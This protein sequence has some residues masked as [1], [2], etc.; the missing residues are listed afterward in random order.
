M[1]KKLPVL[2]L[3]SVF[4]IATCGLIYELIA[5][6]LASYLLGDSVTQFSTIIGVYLFSMGLGSWI[7]KYF[8][9]N[10]LGWFI[11]I[12][13]LVGLVGGT[14][15]S[16]L[17]LVF[18]SVSSFRIILYGLI[19]ITGILVGL[20]IPLLMRIL[21]DRFEFKDLV[22][23][24][25]TFDYI[26]ALIASLVFPLLLIPYLGIVRTA[27]LFGMLN[28]LVALITCINFK[29]E[30][31]GA[32]YLQS[33]SMISLVALLTGFIYANTI[34]NFS[35]SLTYSDTIIFSKSTPYQRIIITKKGRD[36][37]LFLNGNLQFSSVDEYRYHEALIHPVLQALP[38]AKNVLVMGG[39]DGLAVREILKY[40]QIQT[41]TLVDLDKEM[42]KLFR[43]NEMLLKLNNR[44]FLSPKVTVINAD[45]FSWAR[46]QRKVYDAIIIDFPD[47]SNYSVGKL[48]TNAFYAIV[49]H[50]LKPDGIMVVQST[51]PYVA[52]KSYYTVE[53]T[54]QS[55]GL[56]TVPYHNY[57]PSFG[58]WGYIMAMSKPVYK[59]PDHYLP[60]L[61]FM[62][63]Q[64]LEQMLYF[65]K[66]MARVPAQVNKLNNQ[67]LVKYFEDEW[68][69][70]L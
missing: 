18:E 2:L 14:S 43:T 3:V 15:S 34:T 51:S 64:C 13:I 1:N 30:I 36:L 54:L 62:S 41:V 57:V 42:T 37:R 61:R 32:K 63:K 59:V 56:H 21:K 50:L 38:D 47:P 70:V 22:S 66:D 6:T 35:E 16:I 53:K 29:H 19:S 48:Y 12:E 4:I 8:D 60:G 45:A 58:E 17:F 46:E 65:P 49:K 69:T 27:Y 9:K 33:A 40:P 68:S 28:V 67:I 55:V 24:V 52:P 26:G 20:E 39:G 23:K 5:G 7:S 44:S 25:F 31:K 10:L 11:R